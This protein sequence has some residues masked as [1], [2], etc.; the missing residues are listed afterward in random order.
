MYYYD[1]HDY[2]RAVDSNE[3]EEREQCIYC[4]EYDSKE[5]PVV[6]RKITSLGKHFT[7]KVCK[8]C[9]EELLEEEKEQIIECHA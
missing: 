4:G 1:E 6:T 3:E 2:F 5:N 9:L 7:E 8:Q